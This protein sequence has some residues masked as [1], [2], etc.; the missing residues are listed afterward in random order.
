MDP[1]QRCMH[2]PRAARSA[3]AALCGAAAGRAQCTARGRCRPAAGHGRRRRADQLLRLRQGLHLQPEHGPAATAAFRASRSTASVCTST[4]ASPISIKMTFNTEYTGSGS[5]RRQQG[6]GDGCDR[7]LRIHPTSSTSG[8]GRFL[9]PSDRAN[10]Y[11][12]YYAND[13]AP[14]ADGVADY[15]PDVAV[16]RD[17]GLAYWGDFGMLKVQVGA[18]DGEIAQQRRGRQ[19]PASCCTPGA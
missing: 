18:F 13:W 9:P 11:G 15:Y 7:P 12:P 6:R 4:A 16:G 8:P 17:N 1:K 3:S 2:P 19:D 14:Y 5:A 10:L